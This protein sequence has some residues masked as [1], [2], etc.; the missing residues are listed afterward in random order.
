MNYIEELEKTFPEYALYRKA[1]ALYT[2]KCISRL[3]QY[4][5]IEEIKFDISFNDFVENH[6]VNKQFIKKLQRERKLKRIFNE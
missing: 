6:N 2:E 4:Y 1:Y 5:N 3:T